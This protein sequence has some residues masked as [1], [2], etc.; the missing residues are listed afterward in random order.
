MSK[1]TKHQ[2]TIIHFVRSHDNKITKKQACE[3]IPF[4]HNTAKQVGDILSRMVKSKMLKRIKPGHFE[5]GT[6]QKQDINQIVIFNQTELS[7]KS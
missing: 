4:Y 1:A 5:L 3:L 6:G 7:F 2:Q